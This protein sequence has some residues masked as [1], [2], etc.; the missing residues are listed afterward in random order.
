[1]FRA[2]FILFYIRCVDASVSKSRMCQRRV[3]G[4]RDVLGSVRRAARVALAPHPVH[5]SR[6]RRRR[7]TDAAVAH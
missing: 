3:G 4:I 5:G 2:T 7:A 1:M 6:R